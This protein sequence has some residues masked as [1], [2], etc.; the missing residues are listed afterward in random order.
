[1]AHGKLAEIM[2][3][4][5]PAALSGSDCNSPRLPVA[6]ACKLIVAHMCYMHVHKLLQ[7]HRLWQLGRSITVFQ[8]NFHAV[9]CKQPFP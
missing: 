4:L 6:L 9:A 5:Q 8:T 3:K 1:V 2:S 7:H